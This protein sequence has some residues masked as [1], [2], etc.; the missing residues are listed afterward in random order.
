MERTRLFIKNLPKHLTDER[1]RQHFESKGLV[2]DAKIL[3]TKDGESRKI[4][5]IGFKD[6]QT[7]LVEPTLVSPEDNKKT[8][9]AA[10][11]QAK[12][13]AARF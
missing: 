5:F 7:L 9:E 6:F 12:A 1:F 11:E 13:M 10:R 4:G 2:T 3:R 8:M